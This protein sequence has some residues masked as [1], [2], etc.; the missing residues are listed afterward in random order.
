MKNDKNVKYEKVTYLAKNEKIKQSFTIRENIPW[1]EKQQSLIQLLQDKNNRCCF[2]EGPAGSSKTITAIYAGL[3]ELNQKKV[4]KLYYIRSAVESSPNGL[5]YLPGSAD[6]KMMHYMSPLAEKLNE[7]LTTT[8]IK[9]LIDSKH[10]ESLPTGYLRGR[11]FADSIIVVDECF[12]GDTC[13]I[14]DYGKRNTIRLSSLY[15]KYLTKSELPKLKTLNE[16]TG[17]IEWDDI[18]EIKCQGERETREYTSANRK[19]RCTD[20]HKFLTYGGWKEIGDMK[21]GEALFGIGDTQQMVDVLNEDQYQVVLG[22][23]L[24]DGNLD[25]CGLNRYRLRVIHGINQS[26]YCEMKSQIFTSDIQLIEK[27]GFSKKPATRFTTKVF[28]LINELPES[29]TNIPEWVL[30]DV[31]CRALAIW[32]MDDGSVNKNILGEVNTTTLWTC[33]FDDESHEKLVH[34]LYNRFGVEASIKQYYQKNRKKYVKYLRL[35]KENSQKFLLLVDKYIHP[36][37]KYKTDNS[38]EYTYEW[39]TKVANKASILDN[40]SPII[41]VENVYDIKMKNNHN[42]IITSTSKEESGIIVHNCQNLHKEELIT[43]MTR[44]GEQ[45][46]LWLCFDPFQSDLK[47]G[48]KEDIKKFVNIFDDEESQEN[49]I[50]RFI[51]TKDDIVRSKFCKFVVSKIESASI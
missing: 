38:D 8:T 2:I 45:C 6:E 27:N 12:V 31:D 42:F 40:V 18:V 39:D 11:N 21:E 9:G 43:I 4:G 25:K 10:I 15:E 1:T 16:T 20:N 28:H 19:F 14:A 47:T 34:M 29:K 26:G 22:S 33:S 23:F 41:R 46:R 5:G 44:I 3:N 30:N 48:R 51:F 24:G 37:L 7:L 17:D 35:N 32:F 50:H 49:G 36:E 13:I